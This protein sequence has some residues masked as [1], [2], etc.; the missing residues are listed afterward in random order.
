MMAPPPETARVAGSGMAREIVLVDGRIVGDDRVRLS[1]DDPGLLAGVTVFETVRVHAGRFL[2]LSSHLARWRR[3][4]W[5]PHQHGARTPRDGTT[6]SG[7]ASS[8][9]IGPS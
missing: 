5:V 1:P 7:N 9:D 8:L 4:T 3:P 6:S 2:D